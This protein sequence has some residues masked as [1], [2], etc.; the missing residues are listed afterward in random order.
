MNVNLTPPPEREF[1]A[2][3]LEQRRQQLVSLIAAGPQPRRPLYRRPWPVAA[4][5][6]ASAA[7]VA[8]LLTAV[9]PAGSGDSLSSAGRYIQPL[10][11]AKKSEGG[12]KL[13]TIVLLRAARTAANQ[14][15][16]TP[17]PDQY[18]YTKS[19]TFYEA[20]EE[21]P[22]GPVAISFRPSTREIWIRPDGSGRIREAEG[23]EVFPTYADAAYAYQHTPRNILGAHTADDVERPGGLGYTDLSNLPTDPVQLKQQIENRTIEGGTPGDAETFTIIGDLLRETAA[24]PAV[25]SA[26]YTIASQ[27]PGVQLVGPTHDQLGRSG[28]GV[29]YVSRGL[30][31]EL[32][33]DPQ[34]SG[35]L[36]EQ[37]SVVERS[38]DNPFPPGSVIGWAAYLASGVV[39][40]DTATT[41]AMP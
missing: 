41:S 7:V 28:T 13:A 9:L 17:G 25:R 24:P 34:T 29:A 11:F 27:L 39:D 23:H 5:A 2:A 40:S 18:I 37:Q 14:P 16:A 6:V 35:L 32:I 15:A 22:E 8:I 30:R 1:P 33:F 21:G 31:D 26:L 4:I 20:V 10:P 3:R 19:E 36:G 38:K 12:R